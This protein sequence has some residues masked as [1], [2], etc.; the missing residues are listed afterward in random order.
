M[1]TYAFLHAP[2][3]L[4]G[5]LRREK[6]A[7]LP[8]AQVNGQIRCF[9]AEFDARVLSTPDRSTSELLRTL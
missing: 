1:P 9:G 7:P 3:P 4:T 5:R 6:N 2:P 8:L